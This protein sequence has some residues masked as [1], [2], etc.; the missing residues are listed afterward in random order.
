MYDQ[1]SILPI[2][3]KFQRNTN[4][5]PFVEI[6]AAKTS[7][8]TG[9][10]SVRAR[11]ISVTRR[12]SWRV[13][14]ERRKRWAARPCEAFYLEILGLRTSRQEDRCGSSKEQGTAAAAGVEAAAFE[15]VTCIACAPTGLGR[16]TRMHKGLKPRS[17]SETS[18]LPTDVE[19]SSQDPSLHYSPAGLCCVSPHLPVPSSSPLRWW[20]TI[21][22]PTTWTFVRSLTKVTTQYPPHAGFRTC[23]PRPPP[24]HLE[25]IDPAAPRLVCRIIAPANALFVALA[26]TPI[27]I[28]A[29]LATI[30]T[31]LAII[32]II[33]RL[34]FSKISF[35]PRLPWDLNSITSGYE[36]RMRRDFYRYANNVSLQRCIFIEE[37]PARRHEHRKQLNSLSPSKKNTRKKENHRRSEESYGEWPESRDRLAYILMLLLSL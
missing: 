21:S 11:S 28:T 35:H 7:G 33:L 23:P 22:V 20:S 5:A 4:E 36:S 1:T 2:C 9:G 30:P 16:C 8:G 3:S 15:R 27:L 19:S 12:C 6:I 32:S 29:I 26:F 24:D 10:R 37:A 18:H 14:A 25:F 34:F 13:S 17:M 31:T